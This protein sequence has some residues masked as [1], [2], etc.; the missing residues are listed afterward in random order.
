MLCEMCGAESDSVVRASVEGSVL[1]VCPNC[2]KFGKVLS[3]PAAPAPSRG[4]SWDDPGPATVQERVGSHQKRMS[5]RDLYTELPDMELDPE[6][7]KRVR[8]ARER[9][10]LT[11]EQ[12]GAKINEKVSVVHKLESGGF[13]PP[14]ALVKKLEK[15]LKVRLTVKA[16]APAP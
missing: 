14:D 8:E 9:L 1:Q 6:W 10:G 2:S 4:S 3:A 7:S 13:V 11:Q 16:A 12:F 15:T 5:E